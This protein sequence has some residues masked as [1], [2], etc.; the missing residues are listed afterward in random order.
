MR[1]TWQDIFQSNSE[2]SERGR[3][4]TSERKSKRRLLNAR[5]RWITWMAHLGCR[6][7]QMSLDQRQWK[8]MVFPAAIGPAYQLRPATVQGNR[9]A[10]NA[11]PLRIGKSL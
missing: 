11:G 10:A 4:S 1:R 7:L 2:T 5:Q 9:R 8:A 3:T 6:P